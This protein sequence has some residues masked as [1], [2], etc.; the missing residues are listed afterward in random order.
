MAEITDYGVVKYVPPSRIIIDFIPHC[1]QRYPT[2][3]DWKIDEDGN[4]QFYVSLLPRFEHQFLVALHEMVEM[5]LCM[6][7]G[8]K[9]K[10]V[11]DFDM[12]WEPHDGITEPGEDSRA[13]YYH[14]HQFASGVERLM[15]HALQINWGRYDQA[16]DALGET[17]A[18]VD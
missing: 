10:S 17:H 5:M 16:V 6:R 9:Q 13:P 12:K 1:G 2:A 18:T 3:G 8:V 15:A 14:H 4:W 11:D 7:F